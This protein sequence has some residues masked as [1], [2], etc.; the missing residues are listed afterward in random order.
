MRE[1][2]PSIAL[3][4]FMGAGKTTVARRVAEIARTEFA[5]LDDLIAARQGRTVEQ[6]IADE[7]EDGFRAIETD[8]L[9]TTLYARA[10]HDFI[11]ALGGGAWTIALN[12]EL[13]QARG[14]LAVWLDAPFASCWRRICVELESH[15]APARP[16]APDRDA[17]ER[18]YLTRQ[19]VY[20]TADI[21]IDAE[22]PPDDI[23][24]RIIAAA[25][26]TTKR[27]L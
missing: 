9:R 18:R 27:V 14:W 6:I 24:A 20:A 11:L 21:R 19:S 17:A 1:P 7:G 3:V 12:R 26:R 4:G 22:L 8:A 15:D 23:A 13:I 2:L 5:D 25:R 10:S 16:L